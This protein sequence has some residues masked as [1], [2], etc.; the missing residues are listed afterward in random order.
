MLNVQNK[1]E[2]NR[3]E[4]KLKRPNPDSL[5]V[6]IRRPRWLSDT[7]GRRRPDRQWL[8]GQA[9]TIRADGLRLHRTVCGYPRRKGPLLRISSGRNNP[10]AKRAKTCGK[11]P[12][13]VGRPREI[14]E[15]LKL[16][17]SQ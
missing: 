7:K 16:Q 5:Y 1:A 11:P 15:Q 2:V 8:S 10:R 12:Y 3:A 9:A 4:Q 6:F 13:T 17:K 14:L